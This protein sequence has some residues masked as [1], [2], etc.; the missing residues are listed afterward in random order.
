MRRLVSAAVITG[1]VLVAG[2]SGCSTHSPSGTPTNSSRTA[3]APS[4]TAPEPPIAASVP[5]TETRTAE[6]DAKVTVDG[7]PRD[8]KGEVSCSATVDSINILI[9]Q[10]TAAI[11]IALSTDASSVQSVGIGS[12]DDVSLSFQEHAPG[13][14][15]TVTKDGNTYTVKGTAIGYDKDH[16]DRQFIQPFEV[17]VACP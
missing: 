4:P 15:A 11:S 3:A 9:S 5:P 13:V 17:V 1:A 10:P 8:V 2:V 14:E 16:P 12:V 7:K 6:A